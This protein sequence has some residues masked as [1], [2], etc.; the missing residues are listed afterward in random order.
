MNPKCISIV[1]GGSYQWTFGFVR[2]FIESRHLVGADIRLM[3]VDAEA[4]DLVG[5]ACS[6]FNASRG[7][8][9]RLTM[10]TDLDASLDGADF[11]LVAITTG[12]L[13][14]M[15]HD[16]K[17]PEHYGI[18]H[19]VG[20]TVGPGGWSRAARNIPVFADIARRMTERCP[21]AWFINFTNPLTVLTR[22]PH[23][24]H[25]VRTIGMCPGVEHQARVMSRLAGA[26]DDAP[27]DYVCTGIDHGSWFTRLECD[28]IDVIERLKEMGFYRSDDQLPFESTTDD[29]HVDLFANRAVFALWR[30]YGYLP[31]I[32]DRHHVENHPFFV[33]GDGELSYGIQ[34]TSTDER[35]EWRHISRGVVERYLDG[36]E[37]ALTEGGHGDDPVCA[38]IEAL[39]GHRTFVWGTNYR[40]V[41]QI[42]GAPPDAVVETR[43]RFDRDGVHPDVSPMPDVL[44]AV[45][46]PHIYRQEAIV[47][48]VLR[49][50]F[51]Q[52]VAV[53]L[54]DPLCSHLGIDQCR[55]M[56]RRMLL[57]TR[58][59]IANPRLLPATNTEKLI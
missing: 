49:G 17:I 23:R 28:G 30:E 2:Q 21:S 58:K 29:P 44:K 42:P 20:D 26:S 51:D 34:R 36:D 39:G 6:R 7:E 4:L 48:V 18:R 22:V 8:P 9:I 24:E 43:C 27:V 38:V 10:G 14:A 47:D 52:F 19:T 16:L 53:V 12:G 50:D 15:S 11:V 59:W 3:D 54:S 40:N 5:R 13:E 33:S 55:E 46:F 35:D 41:G 37:T 45:T 25:G 57:A 31:S 56:M 32:S 1:G